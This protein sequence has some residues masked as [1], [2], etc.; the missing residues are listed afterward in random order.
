[1]AVSMG[2]RHRNDDGGEP[3]PPNVRAIVED[4]GIPLHEEFLITEKNLLACAVSLLYTQTLLP[5]GG[6][7]LSEAS[8]A[9]LRIPHAVCCS[10]TGER[11]SSLA[12]DK[13]YAAR[14]SRKYVEPMQAMRSPCAFSPAMGKGVRIHRAGCRAPRSGQWLRTP[15]KTVKGVA[16]IKDKQPGEQQM[17]LFSVLLL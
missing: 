10:S 9:Q 7:F 14:L 8:A 11:P 12:S 13:V 17:P 2:G 4:C 3:L 6:L 15:R 16:Y 5:P 1:M